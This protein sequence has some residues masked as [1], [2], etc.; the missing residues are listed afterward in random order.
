MCSNVW[1]TSPLRR[2]QVDAP[3]H[4]EATLDAQGQT[5]PV[6]AIFSKMPIV[7]G[8]WAILRQLDAGAGVSRTT[9]LPREPLPPHMPSKDEAM[10]QHSCNACHLETLSSNFCF[11]VAH[12]P[13]HHP[14][15][16]SWSFMHPI[17]ILVPALKSARPMIMHLATRGRS[18]SHHRTSLHPLE[19]DA[20][21]AQ[22]VRGRYASVE[23][24]ARHS[25][26]A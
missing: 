15:L 6:T 19:P 22:H 26:A 17:P 7:D 4:L 20:G 24:C 21:C 10:S 23:S 18:L 9:E 16:L 12:L 8:L 1:V 11:A 13:T 5:A 2:S 25:E 3:W 14:P